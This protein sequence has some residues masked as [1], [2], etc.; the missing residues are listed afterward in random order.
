MMNN[1]EQIKINLL[2]TIVVKHYLGQPVKSNN[3]GMWYKSPFR[4]EKTASFLV[5]DVKGIHDFGTSKHYDIISFV[6]ELFNIDFKTSIKKI[7]YDFG[8][9]DY[10]ESSKELK[11]YLIKKREE[12][13]QIKKNLDSWFNNTYMKLCIK[14]NEW[15][16]IIP[17]LRKEALAIAYAKEQ[18]IDYLIELFINA[19][20]EDKFELWK[21]KEEIQ[22]YI[23]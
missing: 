16:K 2:P 20:E 1:K 10:D 21:A 22:K 13:I 18:Y 9:I 17:H 4:S 8:I 7:S 23:K 6:E 11:S 19:T 5:N 15:R 3:L 12:E 14:L